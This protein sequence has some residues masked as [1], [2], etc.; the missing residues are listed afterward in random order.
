LR[1]QKDPPTSSAKKIADPQVLF[2]EHMEDTAD[3]ELIEKSIQEKESKVYLSPRKKKDL[4]LLND[5]L[6]DRK[7][8]F[9]G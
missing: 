1:S 3:F 6:K 8:S 9:L 5:L 2:A 7:K 4:Q